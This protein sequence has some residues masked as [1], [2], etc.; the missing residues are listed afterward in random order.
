MAGPDHGGHY[1]EQIPNE[2]PFS[3]GKIDKDQN[4]LKVIL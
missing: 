2:N 1:T 3:S 4:N